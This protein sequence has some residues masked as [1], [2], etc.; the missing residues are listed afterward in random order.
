MPVNRVKQAS[1]E[2][3]CFGYQTVHSSAGCGQWLR[4][5]EVPEMK[6]KFLAA[7]VNGRCV[8]GRVFGS[9]ITLQER[10]F[11]SVFDILAAPPWRWVSTVTESRLPSRCVWR[12]NRAM[13][14]SKQRLSGDDSF[15]LLK[16]EV[17][18]REDES[19]MWNKVKFYFL[20]HSSGYV[21]WNRCSRLDFGL[22]RLYIPAQCWILMW[23]ALVL[24]SHIHSVLIFKMLQAQTSLDNLYVSYTGA[25][26][27]R[28]I[29]Y[30]ACFV[31][32]SA[33]LLLMFV[34]FRF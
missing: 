5:S 13:W 1:A 12:L 4:C 2:I 24:L 31:F 6:K 8:F 18:Q 28:Q 15:R 30:C 20:P 3:L 23:V 10:S 26:A 16:H 19:R 32:S 14:E 29:S 7:S 27:G 9:W 11:Y 17:Q 22:P 21:S 33:G 34:I 25:T